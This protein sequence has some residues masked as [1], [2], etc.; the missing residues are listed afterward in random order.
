[1]DCA[2]LFFI[3]A[4][5][6]NVLKSISMTLWEIMQNG[7]STSIQKSLNAANNRRAVIDSPNGSERCWC[8]FVSVVSGDCALCLEVLI[9][10]GW[11]GNESARVVIFSWDI[12]P[13]PGSVASAPISAEIYGWLS[14]GMTSERRR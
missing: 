14:G 10:V 8:L 9:A 7:A 4:P 3:A 2:N 13:F 1:M 12:A 6:Y 11:A 5:S